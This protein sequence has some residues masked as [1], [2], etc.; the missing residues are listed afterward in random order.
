MKRWIKENLF[1]SLFLYCL[2]IFGVEVLIVG[3]FPI[4]ILGMPRQ[5]DLKDIFSLGIPISSLIVFFFGAI[6]FLA[7]IVL[8]GISFLGMCLG[9]DDYDKA[10]NK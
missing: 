6:F 3:F 4:E 10:Y 8:C 7:H 1:T 9:G 5:F 2:I